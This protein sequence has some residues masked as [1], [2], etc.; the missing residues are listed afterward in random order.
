M[1]LQVGFRSCSVCIS[2]WFPS[3][4]CCLKCPNSSQPFWSRRDGCP[5]LRVHG[6][7][8]ML[9][10]N[11]NVIDCFPSFCM[12]IG[13]RKLRFRIFRLFILSLKV[14]SIF[15]SLTVNLTIIMFGKSYYILFRVLNTEMSKFRFDGCRCKELHLCGKIA[16]NFPA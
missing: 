4:R 12:R 16:Q 11:T 1:G 13:P 6:C 10:C 8:M 15:V 5:I 9:K 3:M 7:W 14:T 2:N